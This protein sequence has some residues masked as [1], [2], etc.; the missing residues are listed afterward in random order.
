VSALAE[1]EALLANYFDALYR[2][3]ADL[4]GR[5]MH[6]RAIYASGDEQPL[7]YRTMDEYLPVVAARPSPQSRGEMRHDFIDSIDIAGDNTAHAQVRCAIGGR[8]FVDFLT[9]V[10]DEGRWQIIAKIFQIIE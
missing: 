7:L 10:R 8:S 3:D 2:S 1:I 4:L 9:M 6:P 5:V